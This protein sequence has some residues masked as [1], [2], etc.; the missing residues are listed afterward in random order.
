MTTEL[1]EQLIK[2]QY[3][4]IRRLTNF[5]SPREG[6]SE[7]AAFRAPLASSSWQRFSN[8]PWKWVSSQWKNAWKNLSK[9]VWRKWKAV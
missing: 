4:E 5:A 9:T 1:R 8:L 3:K 6:A 7:P 2:G